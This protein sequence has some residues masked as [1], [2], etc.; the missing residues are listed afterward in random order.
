MVNLSL[1]S[2]DLEG[3]ELSVYI[4]H[5]NWNPLLSD[6]LFAV[7]TAPYFVL[8]RTYA[9]SLSK[10]VIPNSAGWI[11]QEINRNFGFGL[12]VS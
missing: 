8:G 9:M 11:K 3:S 10:T 6:L 4:H 12:N 1:S 5:L 7:G 2:I